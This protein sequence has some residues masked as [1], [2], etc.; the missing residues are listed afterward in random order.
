VFATSQDTVQV[1]VHITVAVVRLTKFTT[2]NRRYITSV[3]FL[4]LMADSH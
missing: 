1:S 2:T 4:L 3:S